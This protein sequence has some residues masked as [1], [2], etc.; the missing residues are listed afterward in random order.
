MVVAVTQYFLD[1]PAFKWKDVIFACPVTQGS[2][3]TL[4]RW[5][6]KLYYLSIAYFLRNITAKDGRNP[7]TNTG[8]TRKRVWDVFLWDTMYTCK[9]YH[10]QSYQSLPTVNNVGIYCAHQASSWTLHAAK[11][12]HSHKFQESFL[13][14]RK[15]GIMFL[16]ALVPYWPYYTHCISLHITTER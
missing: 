14:P 5:G 7:T 8:I 3:E 15:R 10:N 9:R 1:S 12:N 13:S 4:T 6:G 16:A 11:L 2:A